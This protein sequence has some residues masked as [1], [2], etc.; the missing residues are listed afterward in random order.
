MYASPSKPKINNNSP[1]REHRIE[2]YTLCC[3]AV[4]RL[5]LQYNLQS[6]RVYPYFCRTLIIADWLFIFRQIWFA[7]KDVPPGDWGSPEFTNA[8]IIGR[9]LRP[10]AKSQSRAGF[11][12]VID[13]RPIVFTLTSARNVYPAAKI[14]TDL[15]FYSS[16][17]LPRITAEAFYHRGLVSLQSRILIA[18]RRF[19]QAIQLNPIYFRLSQTLNLLWQ[20][21]KNRRALTD[22]FT[23]FHTTCTTASRLRI[24]LP[25]RPARQSAKA[26]W[27]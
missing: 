18:R 11:H 15:M 6:D 20:K 17:Q 19:Y 13:L 25:F 16:G 1:A 7:E 10:T 23:N 5:R 26:G 27:S 24:A 21:G 12:R 14:T 3:N 2:F 9:F 4:P 22:F 8:F